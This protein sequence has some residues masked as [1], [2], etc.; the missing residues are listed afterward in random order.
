M[1]D[2]PLLD[3]VSDELHD[4]VDATTPGLLSRRAAVSEA[5]ASAPAPLPPSPWARCPSRS[6]RSAARPVRRR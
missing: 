1:N 4:V 2:Q 5:P 3:A 6:P